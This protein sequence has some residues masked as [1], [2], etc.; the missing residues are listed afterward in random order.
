MGNQFGKDDT[1]LHTK[2]SLTLKQ[3]EKLDIDK[4]LKELSALDKDEHDFDQ[5]IRDLYRKKID[6]YMAKLK[7]HVNHR[8][9]EDLKMMQIAIHKSKFL[10]YVAEHQDTI[11]IQ[12][13]ED[14]FTMDTVEH[15]I[16]SIIDGSTENSRTLHMYN[17]IKQF[18]KI[19]T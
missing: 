7:H 1:S 15:L 12:H 10:L 8:L 9:N 5:N 6:I 3:I 2:W 18:E 4:F 11:S 13:Y 14:S 17:I 19:Q 16:N